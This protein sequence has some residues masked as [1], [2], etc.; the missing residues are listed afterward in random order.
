[1]KLDNR[2]MRD[3]LDENGVL[4]IEINFVDYI[5]SVLVDSGKFHICTNPVNTYEDISM[6]SYE[7]L[8][9]GLRKIFKKEKDKPKDICTGRLCG[10]CD[11]FSILRADGE[12]YQYGCAVFNKSIPAV[13]AVRDIRPKDFGFGEEDEE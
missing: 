2:Y 5:M 12:P 8:E 3:I 13:G 9:T 10:I 4:K 7:D 11:K 1:M 6:I